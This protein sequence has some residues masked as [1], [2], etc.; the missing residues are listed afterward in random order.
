MVFRENV[1]YDVY[2][3]FCVE[4]KQNSKYEMGTC[5]SIN[6]SMKKIKKQRAEQ[7]YKN[8]LIVLKFRATTD[9]LCH[10]LLNTQGT[11]KMV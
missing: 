9:H 11:N 6:T 10:G 7:F 8:N 2:G 3:T 1:S 5:Y 4:S